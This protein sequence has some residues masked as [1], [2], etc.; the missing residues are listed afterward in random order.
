[1]DYLVSESS[2]HSQ[3]YISNMPLNDRL[4]AT[5]HYPKY[6]KDV[7]LY[8]ISRANNTPSIIGLEGLGT[9]RVFDVFK[10]D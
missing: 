1:M 10:D 4:S 8:P 2:K 5:R 9:I 7:A 6:P 3:S